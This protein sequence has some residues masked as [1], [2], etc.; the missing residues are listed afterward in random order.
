MFHRQL[1]IT[2]TNIDYK[3]WFLATASLTLKSAAAIENLLT[4]RLKLT[5][6]PRISWMISKWNVSSS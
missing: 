4:Q 6:H 5:K 2:V 1:K 3:V